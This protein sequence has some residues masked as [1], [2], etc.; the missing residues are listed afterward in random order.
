MMNNM[1]NRDVM[2]TTAVG[3]GV[4]AAGGWGVSATLGGVTVAV[5]GTAM[6]LPVVAAGAV[7]GGLLGLAYGMGRN[8]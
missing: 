6:A 7:M 8:R 2:K 4:G 3:A 5:T 1:M